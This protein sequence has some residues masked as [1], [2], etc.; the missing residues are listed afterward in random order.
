V[1]H[2]KPKTKDGCLDEFEAK[3]EHEDDRQT[4]AQFEY[5]EVEMAFPGEVLVE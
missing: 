1:C 5:V 3:N 4:D 2:S